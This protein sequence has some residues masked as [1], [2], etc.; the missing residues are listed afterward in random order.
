MLLRAAEEVLD[1]EREGDLPLSQAERRALLERLRKAERALAEN[2][3]LKDK[4]RR[5]QEELRRYKA[6]APMLAASDRTAEAGSIPSSRVFYR[7][8]QHSPNPRPS[9]G[10]LGHVGHARPRPIPNAPP[11]ALSLS[12]CTRCGTRLGEPFEVRRR[13]ITDL[14]P[15]EPRIF[16]VEIPRYR[17]PGCRARVEPAC[18]YPPNRQYGFVLTARVVHLRLLGLSASKVVDF[19]REAH[20]V[21]LTTAAVLKLERWAAEALG[22]LYDRLKA[23][24]RNAPVVGAD[25]TKFRIAGE[26]GWMWVFTHLNAVVYRIAPS[27]GKDVVEEVL[28][29]SRGVL[30]HDGWVPY[31]TVTTAEH[32]LDLC[33]INRWLER[34]EVLHRVEP[35]PLLKPVEAK[36]VGPG[37]PPTEF[38][39]F[40]DGVRQLLRSS[41]TWLESH[42]DA[43]MVEREAYYRGLRWDLADHL[44]RDW[45]DPDAARIASELWKRREM[46]FTFLIEPGVP[47]H[48]NGAETEIRQGVLYRKISGGRRSWTGAWVLERLLT[49][50]R[51]SRK[52]ELDFL[53]IARDAISGNGYPAFGPPSVAVRKLS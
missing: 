25:E 23:E 10:Q 33:H 40:A 48:N 24:V 30:V 31:E 37:H 35:R 8:P 27:R 42:F 20:G 38:L 17:C 49:V 22:E 16:D 34:G 45:R 21:R 9:G 47:W 44:R 36:M 51:T 18:P 12:E 7:R 5:A 6:C 11:L 14:P 2:R 50:Y 41:I 53:A 26:N 46:V 13:T 32:Q 39:T 52:R 29:G 3:D 19:L 28:G 15:P 4:L 43:P 1:P